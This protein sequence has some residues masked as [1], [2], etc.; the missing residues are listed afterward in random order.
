MG[1]VKQSTLAV[2]GAANAGA[3]GGANAADVATARV[4]TGVALTNAAISDNDDQAMDVIGDTS[5]GDQQIPIE[6]NFSA[7]VEAC[8]QNIADLITQKAKL[9][10]LIGEVNAIS[11]QG[12]KTTVDLGLMITQADKTTVDVGLIVDLINNA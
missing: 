12:D 9:D 2:T 4:V 5:A 11:A 3:T 10:L 1:L 7:L 8:N 6:K